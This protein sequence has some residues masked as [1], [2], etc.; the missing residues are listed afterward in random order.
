VRRSAAL[1]LAVVLLL[2]AGPG[3]SDDDDEASADPTT[4]TTRDRSQDIPTSTIPPATPPFTSSV[5][6]VTAEDLAAS[7]RPGCPLPVESLRLVRLRHWGFDD[8]VHEGRIVVADDVVDD[9]V[10]IFG[11]LYD[12]RYAIERM[13]PVDVYG[14]SD[15]ASMDANNTSAFNCRPATGGTGWSEHAY[16][17]AIDLNPL[18]NPYVRGDTVLPLQSARY[19]DRTST[20]RGV[21]HDGDAA[22]VAFAAQGWVWGGTWQTLKDYQHFSPSGR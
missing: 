12:A 9:V 2:V 15:E 8:V 18:Q 22:V 6:P 5:E 4:I 20:D 3:C 11:G 7:W 16:G 21:I 1:S 13:E 17:R 19:A 10:A 14:G